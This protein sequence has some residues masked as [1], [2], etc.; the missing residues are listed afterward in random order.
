MLRSTAARSAQEDHDELPV[1]INE[2][3]DPIRHALR[4]LRN[5]WRRF[6]WRAD[7]WFEKYWTLS[8]DCRYIEM[9]YGSSISVYF[10]FS[11]WVVETALLAMLWYLVLIMLPHMLRMV[12]G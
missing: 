8:L 5:K 3:T 12:T 11:R 9:R 4:T 6:W 2:E 1:D 7:R 10:V